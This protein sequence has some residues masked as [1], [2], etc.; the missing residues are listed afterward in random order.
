MNWFKKSIIY[1]ARAIGLT[2]ARLAR[3]FSGPESYT[4]ESVT[5]SSAMA[6]STTWACVNLI[7]G[8]L[9]SL[10][11]MVYR[12]SGDQRV[13][14]TDHPLYKLLH[15]SPN[16]DQTSLEFWEFMCASLELQGNAYSRINR[17]GDGRITSLSP[18]IPAEWMTVRRLPYGK[19]EYSWTEEGETHTVTEEHM[20]HLRGFGGSPLG[21]LST[22][23]FGRQVFGLAQALERTAATT[24]ANGIR[25]SGVLKVKDTL[26]PEQRQQVEQLLLEK[27]QG[28][29]RAG[30]PLVL[31]RDME[32]S[33]LTIDPADAQFLESRTF[34]VEEICRMFGVPPVMIGHTSKTSSW[35]SSTEQQGLILQ[36]FTFRRRLKRIEQRLEKS[37][38]TAADRAAGIRCEF[39]ME[40]I[41][42]GDSGARA[43]F[44]QIALQNGWM[45]INE[46]RRLENMPPVAGGNVPR[47]QMQNVP[48]TEAAGID[49]NGGPTLEEDDD[50]D[51]E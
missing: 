43:T 26:K 27:Y 28:A 10:P 1:V 45:T 19:L 34:S 12:G 46:V 25:P 44:Y 31:D 13:V 30:T 23:T 14:A 2:D 16:A 15:D 42:R 50:T 32:W 47:M 39:N 17:A 38:L 37:L 22:L 4:G 20:L 40:G 48:I 8:T 36:K 3:Y 21:G 51:E 29:I 49:H 11:L 41:L 24:F 7:A 18:P 5:A 9:A 6:L 33:Q 35:P